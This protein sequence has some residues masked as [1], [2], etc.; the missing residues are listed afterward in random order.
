MLAA[1]GR[2]QRLCGAHFYAGPGRAARQ[3]VVD[4]EV[5]ASKLLKQQATFPAKLLGGKRGGAC[6]HA[7]TSQKRTLDWT[8]LLNHGGGDACIPAVTLLALWHCNCFPRSTVTAAYE[9]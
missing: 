4:A 3:N 9:G 5:S 8:A 2:C 7:C 6:M 1:M